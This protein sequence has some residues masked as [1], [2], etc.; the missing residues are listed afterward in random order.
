MGSV[1]DLRQLLTGF[2]G[3]TEWFGRHATLERSQAGRE[4]DVRH[5]LLASGDRAVEPQ[6]E[7]ILS[8]ALSGEADLAQ[9]DEFGKRYVLDF[10]MK[11]GARTATV[12]SGWIVRRG[13]DVPRFTTCFV[14]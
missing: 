13:E 2:R 8:A 3:T 1:H 4:Q 12:R 5:P 7:A 6:R 9:E 10:E 11:T 14:L